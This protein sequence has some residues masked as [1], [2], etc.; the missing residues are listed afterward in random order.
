VLESTSRM[1]WNE[2]RHRAQLVKD[3]ADT[4]LVRGSESR[5]GQVFLNLLVNAA[6]AI[7]EGAAQLNTI[8][9]STRMSGSSVVV[10]VTD[11]GSGMSVATQ[12]RLFTPFFTTKRVGEG[13][14]L[15]L[16]IVHRIVSALGGS[17]EVESESQRGTT[18][19]VHLQI[20]D[21][22]AVAREGWSEGSRATR[23]GRILVIDDE[24]I[25]CNVVSR[26]LSRRHEVHVTTRASEA[27]ERIRAGE[28][29]DI[30]LCDLMMP[31]MTGMEL[32]AQLAPYNHADR[33]IFMTGG[34]FTTAARQFLDSVSN[35]RIEKPFDRRH[36]EALVEDRLR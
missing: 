1:A 34:A 6:Q 24:V 25:I 26:M 19:R 16:A 11:T 8:R 33:L 15:G 31:V 2:I 29:F 36:L 5:L 14:G 28:V 12:R 30:I 18:F 9:I 27:L 10:E 3:Y 13:T 7:P 35:Q 32:Y 4:P 20:A 17:I 22:R 21:D 23:R